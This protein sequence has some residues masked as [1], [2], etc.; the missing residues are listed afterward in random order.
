M[1]RTTHLVA[2][3]GTTSNGSDTTGSGGAVPGQV[4]DSSTGVAA[5]STS[6]EVSTT[7]SSESTSGSVS[8]EAGGEGSAG[9]GDSSGNGSGTSVDRGGNNGSL[10]IDGGSCVGART[11]DVSELLA[12]VALGSVRRE[13]T[14]KGVRVSLLEFRA[15][16][17][18][19]WR[20]TQHGWRGTRQRGDPFHRK[21]STA[22][23]P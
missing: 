8:S 12:A 21:S 19:S 1:G 5:D 15:L 3:L 9:N 7:S 20:L 14:G 17:Q 4:V 2:S 16:T 18:V 22:C 6:S 23:C 10:T 11:S 13:G